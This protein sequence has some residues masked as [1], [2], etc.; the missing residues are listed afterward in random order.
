ML[1]ATLIGFAGM[2]VD[3]K[4]KVEKRLAEAALVLEETLDGVDRRIPSNLLSRAHC[5]GVFPSVWK[6][7]FVVGGR[8]GRGVVTCRKADNTWSAPANFSIEGGNIGF[9]IGGQTTDIVLLFLGEKSMRRLMRTKFTLGGDAS[10]AGGPVGRTAAGQTD[11]LFGAEIMSYSRSRGL[12][13]GVALDGSTLRPAHKADRKLYQGFAPRTLDIL[14]G[15]VQP[16]DAAS[17][18]LA[19]LTKYSPEKRTRGD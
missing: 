15:R 7:A 9:Q 2:P 4:P 16:P 17:P 19:V 3:G 12:F 10:V 5:V 13:A 8:Y 1:L 11:A 18:L 6:G 14:S